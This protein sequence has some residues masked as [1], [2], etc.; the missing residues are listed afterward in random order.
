MLL[1]IEQ[2]L[3]LQNTDQ[4]IREITL[5]LHQLPQEKASSEEALKEADQRL[6]S[7]SARQREQ[8]VQV[9]KLQGDVLAKNEQIARYRTQQ[10]ATRKNDEYTAFNHEIAVGEAAIKT[11][12]DR[13]LI[14]MEEGETLAIECQ[15]AQEVDAIE[16]KRIHTLL[17]ALEERRANLLARQK[18][19]KEE[20]PRLTVGIDEELLERYDR[21]FKSKHGTA[22]VPLEHGVC[23][24]CHMQVTTQTVLSTKAEK[25]I[26]SCSQCGRIFYTEED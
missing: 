3:I 16:R 1:S 8:E 13:Q 10:Q 23:T 26:T 14:L 7:I 15:T 19:L 17:E 25:E 12:E 21:L 9:K 22:V 11:L 20:R 24:G 2:L 4:R 18:E 6:E 5:S